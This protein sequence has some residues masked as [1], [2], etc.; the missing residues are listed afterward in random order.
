MVN[1]I[2]HTIKTSIRYGFSLVTGASTIA[3]LWGYT[4]RDI[5]EGFAW[6]KWLLILFVTFAILSAI[7]YL[8]IKAFQHRSYTT[9]INGKPV[10]IR[11]GDIFAVEGWKLIPCNE[12]FDIQ[13]DDR[14]IAHNTLNGKM[15]DNYVDDLNALRQAIIA[16]KK[17]NSFLSPMEIG[18]KT[19]YPLGRLIP[20]RDFLMLAFSHF[21]AQDQAYIGI[22]EYE[23][24]LIRMWSEM[25]RVYAAKP[26]AIPLI[27][28]GI[29]DI[30]G[31]PEK[32]Y[33]D[34]LRCILCTLR[35]SKFKPEQGVTIVLTEEAMDRIDMNAI[36][37]EF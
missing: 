3:G 23:Q 36:R 5:N 1:K 28:S 12:R 17:D 20:Y 33:T 26:I 13:V 16:A 8:A 4:V 10:T 19:I 7:I 34:F 15:I 11:I 31:M 30:E 24:L 9:S 18:D 14:I 27:G 22:G 25:R 37:E 32:N 35:S 21:D 29:T 6:W 2:P